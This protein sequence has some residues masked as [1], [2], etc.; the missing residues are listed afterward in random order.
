MYG[1]TLGNHRYNFSNLATLLAKASPLRSGDILAGV[2]AQS[3]EE[4]V[5]AQFALADLPLRTFLEDHLIS[6]E[7]DEIT[8]L[9]V[10]MHDAKAFGF[11]DWLLSDDTTQDVLEDVG[12]GGAQ[13]CTYSS[14]IPVT[15]SSSLSWSAVWFLTSYLRNVSQ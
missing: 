8:R 3:G 9:I 4:R 12:P 14:M 13:P 15:I 5:A 1:A 6:Y 10:D 11:R 7:S 2:A